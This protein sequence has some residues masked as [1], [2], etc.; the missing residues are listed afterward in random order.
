MTE[1]PGPEKRQGEAA[2]DHTPDDEGNRAVENLVIA[3]FFIV[4]VAAGIWL[5]GTMADVRKTQDCALQGRRN[6]Q[7]IEVPERSR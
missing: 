1:P 2:P 7:T 4:L 6:C 5:L 3:G